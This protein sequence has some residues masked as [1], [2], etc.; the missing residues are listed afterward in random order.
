M[1][2]RGEADTSS[3]SDAEQ[4][5]LLDIARSSLKSGLSAGRPTEVDLET[6]PPRLR[7]PR[8]TFVTLEKNH[9]LRGCIGSLQPSRPLAADVAHNAFAAAFRDPRFPPLREDELPALEIHI[10]I[11]S[12]LEPLE[13]KSEEDLLRQLRPQV[14]GVL[15]A[16]GFYQG[17]FLPSVWESLPDPHSFLTH[18]K[19]KAGLPADYWSDT[20]R[21]WRYT[22]EGIRGPAIAK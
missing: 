8:A 2:D 6:L 9:D 22:V 11:L 4:S 5:R 12:P 18:L 3:L 20:I 7:E 21:A 19:L 13:F 14:D 16:D 15:L 17:T 1:N 10:S